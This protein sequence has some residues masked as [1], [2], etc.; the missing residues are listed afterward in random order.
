MI[1]LLKSP[2]Q[3]RKLEYVNRLGSEFLMQCYEYI[4]AGIHTYELEDLAQDFCSRHDVKPSFYGYQGFPHLLCVSINS[5]IIHGFPSSRELV[6]GDLVSVDFGLVKDGFFS[7]AAFTKIVGTGTKKAKK[8]V[9]CT[10]DALYDGIEKS[11]VGNGVNDISLA[12]QSRALRGRYDVV[13]DFVGHGVGLALHEDPKVPN[14]MHNAVNWRLVP[15]MVL[16]IEPML[17]EGSYEYEIGP[18]GWTVSTSDGGLSTHFEHSVV[19]LEDG[20]KILSKSD[21]W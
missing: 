10:R 21:L 17:V 1:F 3:I 16:A 7:D 12:I 4:R 9:K 5:E 19:I 18:N 15:G 14:Y 20:P 11:V 13:R 2:H 6:S 8:I